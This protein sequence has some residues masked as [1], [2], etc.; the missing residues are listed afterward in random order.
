MRDDS[1][2]LHPGTEVEAVGLVNAVEL[3]GKRGFVIGHQPAPNGKLLN[4]VRFEQGQTRLLGGNS[5]RGGTKISL[6]E[7]VYSKHSKK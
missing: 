4:A 5:L 3:N 7:E 1:G 2:L 6:P